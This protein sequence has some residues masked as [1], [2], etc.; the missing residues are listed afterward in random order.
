MP[1]QV[2]VLIT[3]DVDPFG[4]RWAEKKQTLRTASEL[5][6]ELGIPTT[7]FFVSQEA[8]R[9]PEEIAEMKRTGH[10]I[11]CHG[12]THGDEEEYNRMPRDMQRRYI[13]QATRLLEEVAGTAITAFRGPRVKVSSTTLELLAEYGYLT[14]SSVCSQRLDLVS[15]NL[16]NMGWLVAPRSPYHPHRENAFK[17]GN[18]N[19][20]EVPVSALM[21]PFISS[22]LY[23][24]RLPLMKALF[25]LLYAEACHTNKPIVYL[26]H[27]VEFG[28]Q[29]Y[30]RLRWSSLSVRKLRT[31]GLK[32]RHRLRE[33]NPELRLDLTRALFSYMAAFP[34]VRFM[35]MRG[36]AL[37]SGQRV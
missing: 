26:A 20:L 12:L 10:E 36:Y 27:P 15:S 23:T 32:L 4:R 16:I 24:L 11:G 9:H 31:H 13:E 29:P 34:G 22:T 17:R 21:I 37:Q 25:R 6:Q 35:T 19:I 3:W 33:P 30:A 8:T 28:F 14:D 18:L 2:P 7:F 1:D 5:C